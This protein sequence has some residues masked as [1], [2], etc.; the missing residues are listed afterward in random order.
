MNTGQ[1]HNLYEEHA[2]TMAYIAVED[3]R[4]TL[5]IGSAFHVGD[6]VFVSARHVVE[7][8]RIAEIRMTEDK[9]ISM[10]P[11][12]MYIVRNGTLK[13][14][15]GPFFHP[16]STVDVTVFRV[17]NIDTRTPYVTLGSHVDNWVGIGDFILSEAIVLG[18]PPIP[19]TTRPH[20]IAARAEIN[21]EITLRN[22]RHM[23]FYPFSYATRRL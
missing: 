15:N 7:G 12:S 22:M 18:Y 20:L 1:A 9:Y 2:P 17:N 11:N 6:G 3:S 16:D 21:A 13:I 8:K 10:G 14:S 4:G 23:Y 5:G 19:F